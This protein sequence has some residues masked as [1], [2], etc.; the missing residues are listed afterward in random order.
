MHI[1]L[2]IAILAGGTGA[3][4][5]AVRAQ[6]PAAAVQAAASIPAQAIPEAEREAIVKTALDYGDGFCS[7]APERMERAL[8]P[9]LH[10]VHVATVPRT[11]ARVPGYTTYSGLIEMTRAKVGLIDAERRKREGYALRLDGDVACAK[12]ASAQYNDLLQMVEVD[13]QWKIVNVLSR[14][15]APPAPPRSQGCPAF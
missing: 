4:F 1:R 11:A 2:R 15:N 10:K 6:A 14:R 9:D 3:V 7:G 8:H 12:L 5:P 13:G